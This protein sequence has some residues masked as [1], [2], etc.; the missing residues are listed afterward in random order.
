MPRPKDL[1]RL[2]NKKILKGT[3]PSKRKDES[4]E[5]IQ[6]ELEQLKQGKRIA[7]VFGKKKKPTDF[8]VVEKVEYVINQL[9]LKV[10][11]IW[12][13]I[14]RSN[15]K[16]AVGLTLELEC[17][18]TKHGKECEWIILNIGGIE[19]IL[20]IHKFKKA[21]TIHVTAA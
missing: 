8:G 11:K 10:K 12:T 13:R 19:K 4:A 2:T 14:T 1:Y 7:I 3:K 15:Y 17:R 16:K 21:P 20:K 6:R 9:P 18:I 5:R